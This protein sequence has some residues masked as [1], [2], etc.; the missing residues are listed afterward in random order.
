MKTT[1][2]I[3]MMIACASAQP[4]NH[5]FNRKL[6]DVDGKDVGASH[7]ITE[8]NHDSITVGAGETLTFNR[9]LLR[10]RKL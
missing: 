10:G 8:G 1:C 9:K 5:L 2:A 7:T 3:A 4:T 6:M